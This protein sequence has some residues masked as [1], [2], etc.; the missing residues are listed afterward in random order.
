[1]PM[2]ILLR[3]EVPIRTLLAVT[4]EQ[5]KALAAPVRLAML[6]L[7]GN[8]PMSIDELA[9]ELPRHG[10]RQA[11]NTLRHHL[12]QLRKAGL[13]EQAVLQQTRGAVLKFYSA[14]GRPLHGSLPGLGEEDLQA[15]SERMR[16][17]VTR[18]LTELRGSEH[19]RLARLAEEI[20]PCSLCPKVS[21]EELVLLTVMHRA[22][23]DALREAEGPATARPRSPTAPPMRG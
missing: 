11:P 16:G 8:R 4:G 1:M 23:A 5:A 12:E 6:E 18:A 14:T 9:T 7:L 13:V 21:R 2:T 19:R 17:P 15:L 10:F 3:R 20:A 22:T